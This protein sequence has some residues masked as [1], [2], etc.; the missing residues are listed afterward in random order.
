MQRR[1]FLGGAL[2]SGAIA[3]G[4]I[5]WQG[6]VGEASRLKGYIR[7][8]WSQDRYTYGSYSFMAKG[9][10]RRDVRAL[11]KPIANRVFFAG[12]AAFPKHNST[13]H[14][15][16]ESGQKTAGRVLKASH[17]QIA[18]I[19]A[20]MS[21]L[22]T[23]HMLTENGCKVTVFEARNRLGGRLWTDDRHGVPL[24]LGASWIHGIRGNPLTELSDQLGL[25]RVRTDD[26]YILR[27]Q[28]GQ[29]IDDRDAPDWLENV[30]SV[31]QSI[32]ADISEINQLSYLLVGD[33]YSGPDVIFPG[34]YS[35][36][37]SALT[38]PYEVKLETPVHTVQMDVDGVRLTIGEGAAQRF[39]AVVVT[40]PLGALKQ[41]TIRFDPPLPDR[42]QQA[43]EKLG[44][45]LL[46]K[47]YL[48]FDKPFW[49]RD[50]TWIVT[51]EN[52]LPRGQFNQWLNLEKSLNEPIM[53][54]FNGGPPA[55]DLS[56]FSDDDLVKKAL[57]TLR[58]AY[59]AA[60]L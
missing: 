33:G 53:V 60:G 3:A 40:V 27:G 5:P 43:I 41:G 32:G 36:I 23:A 55:G 34:G 54:A 21:G 26:S 6:E 16:Y 39:D 29:R 47:V 44:M 28:K 10:S 35:E 56:A 57:Q 17:A 49:D 59:P 50:V 20:G 18:I 14:A 25:R 46:D 7:T 15:A 51:P 48:L 13:V 58:L 8:N 52:D 24:D 9:A 2:S 45:G 31:Q 12:E 4:F 19:G 1:A 22:S 42:K 38:G 30:V 11:E 37:L